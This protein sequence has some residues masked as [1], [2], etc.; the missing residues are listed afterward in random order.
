MRQPDAQP[1]VV[2]AGD[3]FVEPAIANRRH[4]CRPRVFDDRCSVEEY[5]GT[6]PLVAQTAEG[7]VYVS[8]IFVITGNP[9]RQ[10]RGERSMCKRRNLR[11]EAGDQDTIRWIRAL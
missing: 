3:I 4:Q 1:A 5:R 10:A 11:A 8:R 9:C 6:E 7:T 2:R